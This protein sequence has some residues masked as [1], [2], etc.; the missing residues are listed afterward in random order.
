MSTIIARML[1]C[2][3]GLCETGG[4]IAGAVAGLYTVDNIMKDMGYDPNF[5][6]FLKQTIIFS[7]EADEDSGVVADKNIKWEF[8]KS[9]H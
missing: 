8:K 9:T 1:A 7:S 4:T 5:L 6:P 2:S 3:K